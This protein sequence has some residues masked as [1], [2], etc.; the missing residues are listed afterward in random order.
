MLKLVRLTAAIAGLASCGDD[1]KP[2]VP[3]DARPADPDASPDGPPAFVLPAPFS[4]PLSAAGPDQLQSATAAPGGKFYAAGFAG[5]AVTGPRFVTVVKLSRT[6]HDASFGTGGVFTSTVD[7]R[8]GAGEVGIATQSSGKI[9]VSATVANAADPND[10]DIAILRLTPAGELDLTFGDN[11]VRVLDLNT[12]HNTGTALVGLDA[13]RGL[14]VDPEGR[15]YLYA[16]SRGA[17]TAGGGGPRTDT[18]FTVARLTVDGELDTAWGTVG[19]HLLD[20]QESNATP[21]GLRA[22]ADGTVIAAGYANSLGLGTTQ[23]VLYKLTAA[24]VLDTAWATGGVFHDTVLAVQTEV[25]NFAVHGDQLVTG[26]YGRNAGTANDYVSLRFNLATGA[27]DPAWGGAASG[28]VLVDPSGAM[29]GSNCRNAIA[30]PGGRTALIGSTGPSNLP[31][32]DAVLVILDASGKVDTATYG[33][34]I[35]TFP[36]GANG[37]D[38]LWGGAVSGDTAVFIGYKGGGA[39]QTATSNDDAYGIILPLR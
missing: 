6:G 39:T 2:D 34:G 26:G 29:L 9:V 38:Q 13:A 12:A 37:N 17:G 18:D 23:P 5:A 31:A 16:A 7:F 10:R 1:H 28:A 15:I 11:G 36:L 30:L 22:F 21:R 19:K 25:Y 35:H 3:A 14:A 33:D 20:I 8:G 27:R 24:G 32:Q 4:V